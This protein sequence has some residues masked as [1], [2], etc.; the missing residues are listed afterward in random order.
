MKMI[1]KI[2]KEFFWTHW[3]FERKKSMKYKKIEFESTTRFNKNGVNFIGYDKVNDD[4]SFVIETVEEGHFEEF[5]HDKSIFTYIFL[6]GSGTFY[7]DDEEVTVKAG[8]VLSINPGTRIYYRGN[9]KQ[10][11]ITTPAYDAKYERH[12]RNIEK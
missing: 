4:M 7:L 12:I 11:L 2:L 8:D 9:L 3:S 1:L 6:E 10:I 5:V